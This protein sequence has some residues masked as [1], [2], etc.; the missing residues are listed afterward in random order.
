MEWRTKI[1]DLFGCKYPVLLGAMHKLGIWQFAAA[2]AEAGGHGTITAAISAT[3]EQLEKDIR[4]CKKSTTGTFGVNLSVGMCPRID[5]MLE[6]CISENVPIETSLYKPDALA[7]RIKESGLPWIHKAARVKDAA[8]A[9]ELGVDA[10]IIVGLEGGGIKNPTQLP[11]LTT[12]RHAV[13][14]LSVPVI[15]AGGIGDGPSFLGA[16][17]LGAEGV[18]LGSAFLMTKESPITQEARETMIALNL[19]DPEFRTRVMTPRLFDPKAPHKTSTEINW[20][21]AASFAAAG[22]PRIFSV[23]ELLDHITSEAAAVLKERRF[24]IG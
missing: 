17:A 20:A 16:L 2:V 13:R 22:I 10:I 3:P 24:Q 1:T 18:M 11:T 9:Q 23:K 8:H 5:E 4:S 19:D 12:T 14:S 15:A 7:A 6:V 21:K